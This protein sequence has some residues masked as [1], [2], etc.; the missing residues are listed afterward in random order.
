MIGFLLTDMDQTVGTIR[1]RQDPELLR[2][3]ILRCGPV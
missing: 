2:N 3:D 1:N